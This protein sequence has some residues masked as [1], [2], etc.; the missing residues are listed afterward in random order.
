VNGNLK[1]KKKTDCRVIGS[2]ID[3]FKIPGIDGLVQENDFI[4][5]GN[6]TATVI[7]TPGHTNGHIVFYF[8]D[9]NVLFCGDT[10]FV[11]GC[12][13]LFEGS[14]EQMWQS[15]QK[16][17]ALPASTKVYCAHEYSQN[18]CRFALSIEPD[19]LMLVL[20][21]I[22]I[23]E[24]IAKNLPT[25]PS[26]IADELATNPFFR[27]DSPMLQATINC[28]GHDPIDVFTKIRR[29]KDEF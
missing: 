17:K 13:R 3:S 22:K 7:T 19:N 12:G 4:S 27:E 11:M 21:S 9:D 29:L 23:D 15:L 10:L 24:L 14:A 25:V 26:T 5:L 28:L 20:R 2:K 1:L 16:L 8:R 18:N 6:S